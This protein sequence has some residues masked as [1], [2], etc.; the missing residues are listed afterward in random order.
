MTDTT[1]TEVVD[2]T[3]VDTTATGT[4]TP[5]ETPEAPEKPTEGNE[6]AKYRRRLREAEAE[7]D[8]LTM[9][10]DALR[11]A[12]VER[13][14]TVELDTPAGL[15]ANGTELA[16]LLADDGTVDPDKVDAAVRA[17]VDTLGL[18]TRT[19]R[20]RGGLYV[21][22]EGGVPDYSDMTAGSWEAAFGAL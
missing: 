1:N 13:L 16:D 17:A 5:Q 18:E 4:E 3:E 15:W 22:R 8:A 20:R 7:R 10:L 9:Q 19:A 12:E 14:A 2:Q 6:A 11:R 21:P